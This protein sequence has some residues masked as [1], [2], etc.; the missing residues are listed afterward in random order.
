MQ[1]FSNYEV[2]SNPVLRADPY[3]TLDNSR[4]YV[5]PENIEKFLSIIG[6][7]TY[8]QSSEVII[9]KLYNI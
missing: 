2:V 6:N 4:W 3:V 8:I 5:L 9:L 7:Q 1:S